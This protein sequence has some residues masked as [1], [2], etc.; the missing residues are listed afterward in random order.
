MTNHHQKLKESKKQL[1]STFS[2]EFNL[3]ITAEA[4]QHFVNFLDITLNLQQ[5]T[6]QPYRKPGDTPLYINIQSNHPP[7]ILKEVPKSV[8]KRT[9]SL[10][11]SKETFSNAIPIYQKALNESG[12]AHKWSFQEKSPNHQPSKK[13]RK[14]K[15]LWFNPP[16]SKN[17]TTDVGKEFFKLL[18]INF[19]KDSPLRKIFNR[20][21]VIHALRISPTSLAPTTKRSLTLRAQAQ[22]QSV[23]AT[24]P[25]KQSQ[26]ALL[27]ASAFPETSFTR[28]L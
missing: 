12:F 17:V 13:H 26:T 28:P 15:I 8:S 24:T 4:N 3:R 9:S 14:R 20:N 6:F 5:N 25:R 7:S 16:Y 1:C 23:C 21:T 22:K 27:K 19:P 10:S 2:K 18:N 11:D